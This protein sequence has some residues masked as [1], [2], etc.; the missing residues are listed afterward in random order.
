MQTGLAAHKASLER[1]H[2]EWNRVFRNGV[3][4]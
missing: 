4:V 1:F 2:G 3:D